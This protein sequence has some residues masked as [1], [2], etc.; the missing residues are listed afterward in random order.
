M[1][2]V[3]IAEKPSVARDIASALNVSTKKKEFFED[4][5]FIITWAIGHLVSLQEP[6]EMNPSWKSWNMG[7][8]PIIPQHWPLKVLPNTVQQYKIVAKKLNDP[9][10]NEVICATDAGRE[11]E[12]IFRY[13]YEISGCK[14]PIKRLWISSLTPAAIKHGLHRLRSGNDYLNLFHCAKGRSQA[15]WLVGMNMSR[16]FS[17]KYGET[18]SIGRV[19]T[20]TLSLLVKRELEIRN[21]KPEEYK[22]VKA[23]FD[24]NLSH[25]ERDAKTKSLLK[26]QYESW[27]VKERFL[28]K[29]IP[30]GQ[31]EKE[32]EKHESSYKRLPADG[33]LAK[34]ITKRIKSGK[35]RIHSIKEKNITWRPLQFYDLTELQKHA[36]RL[37]GFTSKKTLDI[38]QSLYE[39][40]KCISYPR[41]DS[42]FLSNEEARQLPGILN[43]ITE[44]YS[45]IIDQDHG[46]DENKPLGKRFVD[47]SKVSDHHAIIPTNISPKGLSSEQQKIYDLICRRLLAAW[48][49]DHITANTRLITVVEN[50]AQKISDYFLSKGVRTVQLGWKIFDLKATKNEKSKIPKTKE[51]FLPDGLKENLSVKALK[52]EIKNGVTKPPPPMTDA[53]LLTGMETA[54]KSLDDKELSD[55]MKGRGLG[56]PATRASIIE[57]LKKRGYVAQ[58]T[59]ALRATDKGIRLIDLVSDEIKS[60][61]MTGEWEARL[62]K[63]EKGVVHLTDFMSEIEEYVKQQVFKIKGSSSSYANNELPLP[64]PIVQ[65]HAEAL[66]TSEVFYQSPVALEKITNVDE[67]LNKRFGL[68]SFRPHQREVCESVIKGENALLVMPTGAGKSLCFQL[69]GY[70]REG[71]ALVISPLIALIEDQVQK[72]K[73]KGLSAERIHS[74]MLRDESRAVC[75]EYLRGNLDFLFIAP[76][77][78]NLP[79][80]L[81]L[82]LKKQA[83]LIAIDEAHCISQWG[84]D[85]RPAY[86]FLKNTLASFE[87]VP[88]IAVTATATKNVQED[89]VK[90]L[91][92]KKYNKYIHGFRRENIAINIEQIQKKDRPSQCVNLL[93]DSGRLPAIIYT[94]TRKEAESTARLISTRFKAAAYHA[95]FTPEDRSQIQDLFTSSK[96]DVVVATVA[97]GMGIDKADIRTVIHT[98]LPSS[99]EGYYQEI[100]RAGRDGN[101]SKAYLMHSYGDKKIH[102]Y[103]LKNNYPPV[104]DLKSVLDCIPKN[105]ITSEDL[106]TK[107]RYLGDNAN[108]YLEKI[109]IHGGIRVEDESRIFKTRKRWE[110]SYLAQVQHK[111]NQLDDVLTF[112]NSRSCRMIHLIS[113]FNDKSDQKR[114]CGICDLCSKNSRKTYSKRRSSLP[115]ALQKQRQLANSSSLSKGQ[116][117]EHSHFGKGEIVE[118]D[119]AGSNEKLI[120]SFKVG[121]RKISPSIVSVIQ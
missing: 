22:E 24:T 44:K 33:K 93:S 78:F 19:Q 7:L 118:I 9:N 35:A 51:V 8:L 62:S 65:P 82:I 30:I 100:G 45:D 5:R 55:A 49:Q 69:P 99:I 41:T 36:N 54:G 104:E 48:S 89:I 84:H 23:T 109:M 28:K 121:L 108:E 103:I 112:V 12:L 101:P 92:F 1:V 67:A 16:L 97:F 81:N 91:G 15:D 20:P 46:R 50:A 34:E 73:S 58:E 74:G 90:Q 98:S 88:K 61:K 18:F 11:G 31:N 79:G 75:R 116:I 40:K 3:I 95:G 86:R 77:R 68:P 94:P 105:G 115:P 60:P 10:V 47:G 111:V 56:T 2:S 38:A 21:F 64:S 25:S 66:R 71:T 106:A 72:L 113:Y 59:K 83:S 87:D 107:T 76:E 52:S 17:I 80:F 96:L 114:K 117:V 119:N 85:F 43:T 39:R 63:I 70:V 14:K 4:D 42:R 110:S 57:S 13:I 26:S 53:S 120:V 37:Y 6:H 32:N 29:S 102:E 27:Y